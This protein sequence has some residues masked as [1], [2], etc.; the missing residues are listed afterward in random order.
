LGDDLQRFVAGE[1]I[2]ARPVTG[3]ERAIKWA[4]RRPAIAA[5]TG[6]VAV[7]AAL[8]LGGVLWQW[9]AAV[10]A[11]N[12]AE[13]RRIEADDRRKEAEQARAS[14]R[15]Q[16]ALAE[17]RL[18]DVR[19]NLV[20]RY[21][22]DY[23]GALFLRNLYEELPSSPGAAD[24]RGFEWSYWRRKIASGHKNLQAQ[25]DFITSAAFSPDGQRLAWVARDGTI[26]VWD[27]MAGRKVSTIA[28]RVDVLAYHPDGRLFALSQERDGSVMV[29]DAT[30]GEQRFRFGG[31]SLALGTLIFR[32]DG[33]RVAACFENGPIKLWDTANGREILALD[34]PGLRSAGVALSPDGRT[35]AS[36]D[37]DGIIRVYEASSGREIRVLRGHQGFIH[38]IVFSP[39]GRTLASC[40]ADKTVRLWDTA[41]GLEMR[42]LRGH[43]QPVLSV[44]FAVDGCTIASASE[45]L[46]IK[47]W[48]AEAAAELHTLKAHTDAPTSVVFSP[49]GK[50]LVSVGRD[51]SLKLWDAANAQEPLTLKGHAGYIYSL[52]FS[53]DG[54]QLASACVDKTVRLWDL[55]AGREIHT[56]AGH[57]RDVNSVAFSPD[58]R[59][60]ASASWDRTV[61]LWDAATG[62]AIRVIKGTASKLAFHG[63]GA[64]LGYV[65]G[66]SWLKIWDPATGREVSTLQ[67]NSNDVISVAPSPSGRQLACAYTG[68]GVKVLDAATGREIRTLAVKDQSLMTFSVAYSPDGRSMATGGSSGT[69]IV[70]DAET[71]REIRTLQAH[72]G[73]IYAMAFSPDGRRLVNSNGD[74]TINVWDTMTGLETLTLRGHVGNVTSVT[75]SADGRFLASGSDDGTLK[76]WDARE[77]TTESLD[78]E[79]ARGLI[80]FL[81]DRVSTEADLRDRIARDAALAPAVRAAALEMLADLWGTQARSR[82]RTIV[83]RWGSVVLLRDDVLAGLRARPNA[84]PAIQAACL[85]QAATWEEPALECNNAGFAL[86]RDPGRPAQDYRRG[87][88]LAQAACRR[89]LSNGAFLNTLGVAQYR[90]GLMAPAHQTLTRSDALNGGKEPSDLAFLAMAHQCLGRPTEARFLLA[91]VRDAISRRTGLAPA[92]AAEDQ[93]FLSEAEAVVLYDP[94]FPANPFK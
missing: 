13:N 88:L 61:R 47:L 67:G 82:A 35:L 22:E 58:G 86:V 80:L 21:W 30:T 12:I 1:P 5:L 90:C 34:R 91:R 72:T 32:Q 68:Q 24:R 28:R 62:R 94:I 39:D 15:E 42:T 33:R 65:N 37:A 81:A 69:L 50:H 56:L 26:S 44:A 29:S 63:D 6:L 41:T 52:A 85:E 17:Q 92:Q 7:V 76:V 60:L 70:W 45:D 9:R 14:E 89:E 57:E 54:K 3:A 38:R 83:E 36:N 71:G 16:T 40:G 25:G 11:R 19:M 8:G 18:Y 55:A 66:D 49:D 10:R 84:D 31:F 77:V 43:T 23:N 48:N 87:L 93:A 2:V 27:V 75:F 53:P 74:G 4:R 78:R 79:E 20:Q 59:T 64:L 73:L 46:T 51:R